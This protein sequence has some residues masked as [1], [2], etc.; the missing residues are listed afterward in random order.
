MTISCSRCY[1]QPQWIFDSVNQGK[2][3]PIDDYVAGAVLPSHL[4]PFVTMD[5]D[6]Y[7]PPGNTALQF[8]QRVYF[9]QINVNC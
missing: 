1:V 2:L 6:T 7:I 3:L 8:L 5:S 4:S 9:A